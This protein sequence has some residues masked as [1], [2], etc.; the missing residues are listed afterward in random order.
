MKALKHFILALLTGTFLFSCSSETNKE[1]NSDNVEE[2]KFM[3]T[4]QLSLDTNQAEI[5]MERDTTE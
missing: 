5:V 1:K 4:M 2:A 3:K